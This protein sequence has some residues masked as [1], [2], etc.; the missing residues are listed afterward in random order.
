MVSDNYFLDTNIFLR[1]MVGADARKTTE[2]DKLLSVIRDGSINALTSSV[3]LAEIVWTGRSYY[4]IEKN[5]LIEAPR[6]I[7]TMPY[8]KFD[9]RVDM[10]L[11]LEYFGRH[12]IK[13]VDALIASSFS[14]QVGNAKLV[15]YDRDF[16]KLGV[17]RVEPAEVVKKLK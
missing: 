9:E 16:D 13:F 4:N 6:G 3:V 11:A 12:A 7:I 2:C 8:L 14:L 15:S 5:D 17:V 10:Q 1:S